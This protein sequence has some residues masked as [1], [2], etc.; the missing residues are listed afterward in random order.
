MRWLIGLQ[1]Y[2]RFALLPYIP[3]PVI[4]FVRTSE[5]WG[6]LSEFL[7]DVEMFVVTMI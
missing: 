6:E 2:N 3:Q 5:P 1:Q 4:G 7:G